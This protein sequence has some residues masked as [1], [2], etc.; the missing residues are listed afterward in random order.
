MANTAL[1]NN[2]EHKDL[3]VVTG[4]SAAFGDAVNLTTVFPTEFA[5]VQ[6]DYPILFQR[7]EGGAYRSVALLGFDKGENLF[8][9]DQGWQARH[10]PVLHQRGPFIIGFQNQEVDGEVRREPVI[11]VD[12]DN[13]RVS[14]SEGEPVFLPQG[15]SSPYLQHVSHVLRVINTGAE[16]SKPM[17]EAFEEAGLIEP[18][19]MDIRLDE[20]TTY[21]VP[22]I[23]SIS[24]EK[25][26]ALEGEQ[27]QRLHKSGYLRAAYLVLASLPN[28]NRLIAMKNARRAAGAAG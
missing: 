8:L 15:G 14:E 23:Y 10:V 13:P 20:A 2:T 6:R 28:V 7:D 18:A 24:E 22:D 4:H 16:I 21:K 17:F 25:L 9:T 5:E 3:K 27:L 1:L 11:F 26:A 19:S 12:M